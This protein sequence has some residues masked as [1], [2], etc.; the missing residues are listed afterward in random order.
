MLADILLKTAGA[1]KEDYVYYPRPSGAGT[2]QCIRQQVFQDMKI[3][4]DLE[5]NDRMYMVFDDGHWHEE[6]TN[7]WIRKTPYKLHSEQMPVDSIGLPFVKKGETRFCKYC[8]KDVP[9][10][11]LH[12]HIDG[13]V[14]E[15]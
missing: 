15:H 6:L 8:N 13:I 11:I 9:T 7:D 10:D 4:I 12:G 5:Y 2:E 14:T 1:E 3:P